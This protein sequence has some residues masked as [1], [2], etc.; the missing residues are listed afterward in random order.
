MFL[1]ESGLQLERVSARLHPFQSWRIYSN[2]ET[3]NVDEKYDSMIMINDAVSMQMQKVFSNLFFVHPAFM[4]PFA[5]K[6]G[7]VFPTQKVVG[8]YTSLH[9]TLLGGLSSM[10]R[11]K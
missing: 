7:V 5:V 4:L 11:F 2:K 1:K 3:N 10:I 9:Y 6:L 8:S